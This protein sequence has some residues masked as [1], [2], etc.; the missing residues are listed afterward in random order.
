MLLLLL[1]FEWFVK[2]KRSR[3]EE[4]WS[5]KWRWSLACRIDWSRLLKSRR[6]RLAKT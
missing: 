5:W 6:Q 1:V 2:D 4:K 3:I